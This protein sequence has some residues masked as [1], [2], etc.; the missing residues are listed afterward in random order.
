MKEEKRGREAGGDG[1]EEKEREEK[2]G[3]KLE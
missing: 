3:E 1:K 2:K